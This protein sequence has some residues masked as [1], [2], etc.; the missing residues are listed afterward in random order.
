MRQMPQELLVDGF[1]LKSH[2]EMR[3]I[4]VYALVVSR[5]SRGLTETSVRLGN[6]WGRASTGLRP[7]PKKASFEMLVIDSIDHPSSN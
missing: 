4:P 5:N 2:L 6:L 3:K 7:L 1:R